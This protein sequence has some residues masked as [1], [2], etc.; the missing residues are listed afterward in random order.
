MATDS[1]AEPPA[2]RWVRIAA[3]ATGVV[4][5]A[6]V[7][8]VFA[9]G[10]FGQRSDWLV[11]SPG[12]EIDAVNLVFTVTSATAQRDDTALGGGRWR[13]LV[14]GTVRNPQDSTLQ[15]ETGEYGNLFARD[16]RG[17][18]V[19]TLATVEL[20]GASSRTEVPPDDSPMAMVARFDFDRFDPAASLDV[21]VAT[22]EFTDNGVLGLGGGQKVWNTDSN[23][24]LQLVSVPLTVLPPKTG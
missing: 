8:V 14:S 2:P 15:P 9:A 6:L 1:S 21:A 16:H 10:G 20:G 17:G 11:R 3:V 19:A 4:L 24:L 7:G 23:A 5:V 13:V 18:T 22:M 12:E